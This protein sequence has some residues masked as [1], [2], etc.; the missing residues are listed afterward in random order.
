MTKRPV[1]LFLTAN[2]LLV[3]FVFRDALWGASLLAPLDIAPAFFG[4]YDFMGA[5]TIPANHYT[6]DQLTQDLPVQRTIYE[7]YRRGEIPWWDSY[8]YGG[9]PLLADG[10]ING[11]AP[12][13]V[14]MYF[15]LPFELA[16][17]WTLILHF[18][19]GG[20]GMF[21]LLRQ[22]GFRD[23]NCILFSLTYEFAGWQTISFQHPWIQSSFVYYP[24]LWQLW[25]AALHQRSRWH[26]VLGSLLVAAIFLSGSIQTHTYVLLFAL[27]LGFGYAGK[28]LNEWRKLFT[29]M[30]FPIFLGAC[31][32]AP[33]I[34]GQIELF[35]LSERPVL[36]AEHPWAWLAGIGS[37]SS[38]YPWCLG[39]FR[40]FDPGKLL[41]QP[42]LGFNLY[43]GSAAFVLTVFGIVCKTTEVGQHEPRRAAIILTALYLLILSTP[44]L[45]IFYTRFAALAVMGLILL[46][47]IG[48]ESLLRD[49]AIFRR[50][51]RWILLAVAL[52]AV[53]GNLFAWVIYPRLLP[54]VRQ[55]V[56]AHENSRWVLPTP[57]SFRDF[58][59][60]NLPRE[61]SFQNPETVLAC[62][63]VSWLVLLL[64]RPQ[65]RRQTS[66]WIALL[67]LN[68]LPLLSFCCRYVPRQPIASWHRLLEGGREQ[69]AV[70]AQLAGTPQR[71]LE[72]ASNPHNCVFPCNFGHLYRVHT[73][74]GYTSLPPQSIADLP[75]EEFSGQIADWI[76]ETGDAEPRGGILRSN[77]IPGLARFRWRDTTTR[78]FSVEDIGLNTIRLSFTAS[79]SGQ[80]LWND[81][82]F[83][84][85]Q[86]K[87]DG[88]TVP[89]KKAE[90]RFSAIDIPA[91]AKTVI[92]HYEPSFLR[93]GLAISIA[94]A[95][96]LG[97]I[98]L[99]SLISSRKN[100]GGQNQFH[101]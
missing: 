26:I 94:G 97:L 9:R 81:S 86:A 67:I 54:S 70:S 48:V 85:W 73:V 2:L 82:Y 87:A 18:V 41:G 4:K 5:S 96:V 93:E 55:F 56:Y 36:V 15:I 66:V 57:R 74:H 98:T 30:A 64:F 88:Q 45:K 78:R 16:Y 65:L 40:T 14:L 84:G 92:L 71:L 27:A 72:I 68:S 12:V 101:G 91:N 43:I 20:V 22:F 69:K 6:I 89:R 90:P 42:G 21:L 31:L 8:T 77:Q 52:I 38:V 79:T 99:S 59:I 23:W 53:A 63:G 80:L 35:C 62:L 28:N 39:T 17:N 75:P 49:K 60:E 83:P 1:I 29:V 58:Q 13:R 46:A 11:T 7:A 24:F 47:A 76:Y 51:A 44:L 37:L 3:G 10:H 33:V 61:I 32:A 34:A 95:V 19:L 25:D 100:G 50:S